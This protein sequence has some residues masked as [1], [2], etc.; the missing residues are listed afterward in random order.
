MLIQSTLTTR[1]RCGCFLFHSTL[2]PIKIK[3]LVATHFLSRVTNRLKLQEGAENRPSLPVHLANFEHLR[4]LSSHLCSRAL[5]VRMGP[6]IQSRTIYF[7]FS[8]GGAVMVM[9][10]QFT[11]RG[12]NLHPE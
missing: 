2:L 8:F 10:P 7:F 6:F 11:D 1:D 4:S 9:G 12:S 5:Q 3:M